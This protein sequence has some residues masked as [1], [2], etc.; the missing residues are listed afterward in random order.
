MREIH[1]FE[2]LPSTMTT[3]VELAQAGCPSGTIVVA[4]EQTAGQG[5]FGRAW[6]SEPGAGL[7]MSAIL[8]QKI[9]PDTLPLVTLALG[10]ATAEAITNL[11]SVASD[12]RW[13]ND[14]L[15]NGKKCAGILVQLH[16]GVLIV[17]IGINVS[18]TSFS[19]D[20]A[21]TATSLR[22]ATGRDHDPED[23][24]NELIRA[25]D[26]HLDNLLRNGRESVLR[27]FSQASS[28]VRGRRVTVEQQGGDLT[29]VTEGLDPQGFL[30]LRRDNGQRTLVL[31]GGVRPA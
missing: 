24:L 8:R 30:I 29:G 5:R 21:A 17:G 25:M 28:F 9:C 1:R 14:V 16:D 20:L 31:A 12:L 23:L 18:H 2:S 4:R 19:D 11:A 26:D 22:L 27:A 7:Y 10:L 3:A 13:P 15:L 6:H